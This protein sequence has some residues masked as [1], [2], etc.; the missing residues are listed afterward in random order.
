MDKHVEIIREASVKGK[1]C[2]LNVLFEVL[3]TDLGVMSSRYLEM[4]D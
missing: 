4:E 2:V 3:S 1:N